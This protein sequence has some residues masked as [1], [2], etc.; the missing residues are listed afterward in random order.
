MREFQQTVASGY[1]LLIQNGEKN[2][3]QV[4]GKSMSTILF[5]TAGAGQRLLVILQGL[6][7]GLD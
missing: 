3:L 5:E 2:I 6:R 4:V 1:V 7:A